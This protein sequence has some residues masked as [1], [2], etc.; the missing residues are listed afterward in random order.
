MDFKDYLDSIHNTRSKR[1]GVGISLP[2]MPIKR[3]DK[4]N[5]L[6]QLNE[7]SVLSEY[8]INTKYNDEVINRYNEIIEETNKY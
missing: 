5:M 2:T 3:E 6:R 7:H 4:A 1:G 8:N